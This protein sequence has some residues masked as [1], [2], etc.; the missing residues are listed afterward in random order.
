[1]CSF[2]N[3]LKPNVFQI[4]PIKIVFSTVLPNLD[5]IN[6]SINILMALIPHYMENSGNIFKEFYSDLF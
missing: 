1:M 5:S 2:M 3:H 4:F 6:H